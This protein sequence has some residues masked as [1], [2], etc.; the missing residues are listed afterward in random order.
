MEIISA[1][2][3]KIMTNKYKQDK[4]LYI[5]QCVKPSV[6]NVQFL[7]LGRIKMAYINFTNIVGQVSTF[8]ALLLSH[9]LW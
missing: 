5:V 2:P 9:V 8:K 7:I 1:H 3:A 6:T 4:M